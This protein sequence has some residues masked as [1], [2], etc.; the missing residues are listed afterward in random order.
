M[1]ENLTMNIIFKQAAL[2][3]GLVLITLLL[4][5]FTSKAEPYLAYKNNLKCMACHV[6]PDGGGQRNNFGRA[7]GQTILPAKTNSFDSNKLAQLTQYLTIGSDARFNANAQK[8][9]NELTSKSFEVSSVLLYANIVF[10]DTGLSFYI[11]E[12]IAPGSALNREAWAMM[13]FASGNLL[14]VGKMFLPYGIRIEDDGAFI[15]QVTGMNFDNGDNGIEY[16]VNYQR[17]AINLFMANGTSQ[18]INDD[19]NFLYGIRAEHLFSDYRLGTSLVFNNNE[20][21]TKMFNLY[22]GATWGN[23]TLLAEVDLITFKP[24]NNVSSA[25]IKQ[26]IT[27]VEINYQWQKGLN[28]KITAEYFDPDQDIDENQQTRYSFVTEYTPIANVQLRLGL[29]TKEDIPQKPSQSYD[30]IFLQSHFYF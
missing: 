19:D 5:S 8:D 11:D 18:L 30:L 29:R 4:S 1:V 13:S 7:F 21:Q 14:K 10:A 22:S 12:Q 9:K 28:F 27:F 6:N 3:P 2:L 17:S 16:T 26:L 23:F 20:Q 15:R 25:Q 24:I